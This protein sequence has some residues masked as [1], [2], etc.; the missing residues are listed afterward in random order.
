[1]KTK[2]YLY[3]V[4]LTSTIITTGLIAQDSIEEITV[5][6]SYV[7]HSDDEVND[8]I[9][10][11][12]EEDLETNSSQSLGE[13]IDSLLGVSSADYGAAVGQP[14]IRGMSGNRVK[15]LNNGLV[16]RDMSGIGTDHLNEVD[17]N[18]IK[19]IEIVRGPLS[20]MYSNGAIGG[21]V[22][23]VDDTISRENFADRDLR[24][25]LERQSGN[26]GKVGQFSYKENL[27]SLNFTYAYKDG[28][29]ENYDIPM[30]A[31]IHL[32]EHE[33]GHEEDHD[34]D[35]DEDLDYLENSDYENQSHRLGLSTVGDWGHFGASFQDIESLY[36]IPFHG[37]EH[38]GQGGH[39]EDHDGEEE[40]DDHGEEERIFSTTDSQVFNLE[41]SYVFN[42][43]SLNSM[44]Y[45]Y[46]NSDY[47]FTEQHE[48]EEHDDED[49]NEDH[50]EHGHEEGPT[51]F[52]ND[53][54]EFGLIL[55]FGDDSL[56]QKLVLQNMNEDV[57]IIGAEAFMNPVDSTEK[58]IG[59]YVGTSLMGLDLHLGIRH[60]RVNR[61]GTVTHAHEE[62]HHD[63]DHDED[64]D[65]EEEM[66]SYD[67]DRNETS[68]ALSI[69]SM[70][71]ENTT[72]TLGLASVKRAPSA[73]ELFMNGEHLATGRFEVGDVTLE[74][75]TSNNI[76]LRFDYESN[77]FFANATIFRNDVADYIYLR[78]ETEEEHEMHAEDD[79]DGHE[80]HDDHDDHG[81]L[82]LSN[83][84]QKDAEFSG[85]ELELG[86]SISLN[87]GSMTFS[88]GM[89]Y[90]NAKFKDRTYVPRINPRRHILSMSYAK[91]STNASLTLRNVK[92]QTK[93]SLNET[94]TESYNM[95]DLKLSQRIP[96]FYGD[97]E[98]V[99]TLFA[100]NLLDEVARN[101]SSF[102]KDEV[103]LP[104]RNIG[105]R[106][107]MRF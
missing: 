99:V 29:F 11:L 80:D 87:D 59:Y 6:S 68:M 102:V 63:E 22:N 74:S 53:S 93:L 101:H 60:D 42:N 107:N 51:L 77:G 14:I 55:D 90:V 49:H 78:D 24:L 79:H 48:E 18:A 44:R 56:S 71:N 88:Y 61:Q 76:D 67:I 7:K 62:E 3:M 33:E 43:G 39:D 31:V 73:V 84:M 15:V 38:E 92:S 16:V 58:M 25:G 82:I 50:D 27:G 97:S 21:I 32:E 8:P 66:E 100:K 13:T 83:Y 30:G 86:R 45:F 41:G 46:R 70:L 96:I 28:S 47:S 36:G 81:G 34:E 65:E 35:H 98:M 23:V 105:L 94:P 37:E 106:F 12:G 52:S 4:A 54:D 26:D 17:L 2:F 89:D 40:H 9:H 104:G 5:T 19:Q 72:L 75:E 69:D 91:D 57:S 64:H 20:L 95:L 1:M 85:Y 10:L 103:P